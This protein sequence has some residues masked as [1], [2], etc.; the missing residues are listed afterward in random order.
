MVV[1]MGMGV[2]VWGQVEGCG[3]CV[4]TGASVGGLVEDVGLVSGRAA[5]GGMGSA[6]AVC[7]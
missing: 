7:G 3:C 1:G 5:V 6:G 2:A 4:G